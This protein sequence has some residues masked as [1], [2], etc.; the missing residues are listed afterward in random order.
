MDCPAPRATAAIALWLAGLLTL[1]LLQALWASSAGAADEFQLMKVGRVYLD[2]VVPSPEGER[3]VELYLRAETLI[4]EPIHQLTPSSLAIRDDEEIVDKSRVEIQL[5][6]ESGKG[7]SAVLVLDTSRTM[8]GEPFDQAKAAA[9]EFLDRMGEFDHV[10][11]VSFDDDVSVVAEFG[12]PRTQT[13]L[14]LEELQVQPKTLSKLVW[15]G[16]HKAVDLVRRRP[17]TLPRRA[18]VIL[19]TDGRDSNSINSLQ[20]LIDLAAGGP[21]Q[22]RTPVFTI[23]YSRFGGTGLQSLDELAHGTGASAFQAATPKELGRFFDEIWK[24]MTQSFVVRFPAEMNGASHRI[25][26]TVET[27]SDSREAIYPDISTPI[28]PWILGVLALALL[29][30]GGFVL[31]Q[32]RSAG[33]LTHEGGPRSGQVVVLKGS[34]IRIG[35]L[36]DNEVVLNV[37]TISRYHAQIHVK[38]GKVEVEDLNSKNGTYVN[39]TAV[40]ARSEVQSGDRLRFGDVEMIYRK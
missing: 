19:F 23:G 8:Q 5:L 36:E 37:P 2:D 30:A 34:K 26:V 15:D 38:G 10:A 40:R 3:D 7:T 22:G 13:R 4:G 9:L 1:A 16:A 29:G 33:R 25:E 6:S 20:E 11:V 12:A 28:W 24:R 39:G 14:A 17:A 18:F 27:R 21:G 35:A 31:L 32:S